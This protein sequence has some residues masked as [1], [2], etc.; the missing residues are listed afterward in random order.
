LFLDLDAVLLHYKASLLDHNCEFGISSPE[1]AT[2]KALLACIAKF[3]FI[4]VL[5]ILS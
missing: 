5:C 4:S 1:L 3:P 2:I